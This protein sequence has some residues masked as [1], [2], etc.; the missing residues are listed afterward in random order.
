M[1]K[2]AIVNGTIWDT[3]MSAWDGFELVARSINEGL[4]SEV[5][6]KL[7]EQKEEAQFKER[8]HQFNTP[9]TENTLKRLIS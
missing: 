8:L 5:H 7:A 6:K 1:T 9:I 3:P 4:K 2:R